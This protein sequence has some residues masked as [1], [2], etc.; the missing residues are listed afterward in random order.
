MRKQLR[1]IL[2]IV[3]LATPWR[4][5]FLLQSLERR[6]NSADAANF[7]FSAG[8][9]VS[10]PSKKNV[11]HDNALTHAAAMVLRINSFSLYFIHSFPVSLRIYASLAKKE[12][13]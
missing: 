6:A 9:L 12:K 10:E 1:Q 8:Y 3:P 7:V 4:T 11:A 5:D 2:T 13:G